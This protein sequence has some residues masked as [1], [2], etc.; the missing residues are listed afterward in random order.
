MLKQW[1]GLSVILLFCAL[2]LVN[3]IASPE[4]TAAESCTE[5]SVRTSV[6]PLFP[7]EAIRD[8]A[9]GV[10]DVRVSIETDGVPAD[11]ALLESSGHPAL[12]EA[13]LD[14]VRSW[15]FNAKRCGGQV[16]ASDVIV[17]VAF[18]GV[19]VASTEDTSPLE[20]ASVQ[21]GLAFLPDAEFDVG[22]SPPSLMYVDV[23]TD[24]IWFVEMQ[25]SGAAI[26]RV[27]SQLVDRVHQIR[28]R[29][30][31]DADVQWCERTIASLLAYVQQN[32]PPPPPPSDEK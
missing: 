13:A 19:A 18:D 32:P 14:A 29:A 23:A 30:L 11:V 25:A 6:Q 2:I 17:P 31:C 4:S 3:T 26:V 16:R 22:G 21:E 12:D 10:A 8:H 1:S 28:H 5:A 27:R 9:S 15:T 20:F 7:P 24:R